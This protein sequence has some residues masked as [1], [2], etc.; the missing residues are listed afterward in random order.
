MSGITRGLRKYR[1][2]EASAL[3]RSLTVFTTLSVTLS[4]QS[5]LLLLRSSINFSV[6]AKFSTQVKYHPRA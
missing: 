6:R 2:I 5:I 4:R 1:Q 3:K